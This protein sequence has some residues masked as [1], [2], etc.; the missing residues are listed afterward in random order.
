MG[1]R[2]IRSVDYFSDRD[3]FADM[4]NA[5]L[6]CGEEVIKAEQLVEADKELVDP[7]TEKGE[8]VRHDNV[9]K[10]FGKMELILL[11]LEGQSHV[12][13]HMVLRNLYAEGLNYRKQWKRRKREHERK[14]DLISGNEFIS[15]MKKEEKFVPVVSLVVYLGEEPWDGPRSLYE[16]LDLT[17]EKER[18]IP[19][20]NDYKLNLFDYH[21]YQSFERFRSELRVVFEFLRYAKDRE[22]L[23]KLVAKH[24]ENYY[25]ISE[26]TYQMVALLTNSKELLKNEDRCE[27]EEGG[28]NMCKA[29]ED[30]RLEG[31]EE[32]MEKG[33]RAGAEEKTRCI[34]RNMLRCGMADDDIMALAECGQD[35]IDS[36]RW[37]A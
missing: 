34:V 4:F 27:N 33:M 3:Y 5:V 19:F 29:L 7:E 23:R 36:V 17:G 1:K 21:E 11:V 28:K 25:N 8:G 35:V 9:K 12:D 32:G 18:L 10:W 26:D 30:I 31:L 16:L 13:Y 37:E 15:G 14:Q 6:F 24:P 2:D 22:Q 20:I